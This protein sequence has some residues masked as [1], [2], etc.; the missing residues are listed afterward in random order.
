DEKEKERAQGDAALSENVE[1][2]I[3]PLFA[4]SVA[5]VSAIASKNNVPVIAFSNDHR[6][7]GQNTYLL[8]FQE[9]QDVRRIIS[10]AIIHG[11]RHFAA[12]V[13]ENSYGK[14]IESEFRTVVNAYGG[15]VVVVKRYPAGFGGIL[16]AA[17]KLIED[18]RAAEDS[19]IKIDALFA[20]GG[21]DILNNF[22][23]VLRQ[24][25]LDTSQIKLLGTG[26]WD[27]PN[28]SRERAFLG[29][30]YPAPSPKS[31]RAFSEK[32]SQS[33]GTAPPRIASLAHNAMTIAIRL[34]STHSKGER[35]TATNLTRPGG[36]IGADGI[37]RFTP[38][39]LIERG[40]AILEVR[41]F[42]SRVISPAPQTFSE[43]FG[44]S[45]N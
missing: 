34:A 10:F 39:G 11:N 35:Y 17:H 22:G 33:F 30:W 16:G 7:A 21:P 36:F 13:P 31:W 9:N 20:P 37:V 5:S 3:G 24:K 28:I 41:K 23:S 29:A 12:I 27:Y 1:L 25:K 44:V 19:G 18:I 26:S 43:N 40:L 15:I 38:Y 4:E 2:I 32:F 6:V 8:S 14:T 42:G 45:L